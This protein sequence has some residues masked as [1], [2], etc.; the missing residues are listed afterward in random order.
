[1]R[2]RSLAAALL[3]AG[4]VTGCS[5][6]SEQEQPTPTSELSASTSPATSA[7]SAT[8]STEP[9]EPTEELP[10]DCDAVAAAQQVLGDAATA[11]LERLGIDR[12][13]PEAFTVVLVTTSQG[14]AGYWAAISDATGPSAPEQLRSDVQVVVDYWAALDERLAEIEIAD[15][16][17]AAVQAAGTELARVQGQPDDALAPA[18]QRVQDQLGPTCGSEPAAASTASS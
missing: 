11:E 15:S 1:V 3:A 14:A 13:A 8:S 16:S 10:F 12:S 7:T 5:G 9:T 4:L 6:D 2:S 17:P 18:Q